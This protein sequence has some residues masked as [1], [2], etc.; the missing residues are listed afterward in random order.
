MILFKNQTKT[1]YLWSRLLN[2]PFWTIYNMLFII[3]YKELHATPLQITLTIAIKPIASLFSS[4]WGSLI[5][6]K[7]NKLITNLVFANILKYAPFLLFPFVT[8]IWFFIASFGFYM[9]FVRGTIPAWMEIIKRNIQGKAREHVFAAGSIVDYIGSAVLPIALGWILDDYTGSWRWIFFGAACIGIVSTGLLWTLPVQEAETS[10]QTSRSVKGALLRPWKE[11]WIL[12]KRRPDFAKFQIAFMI[13]G[14]ALMM[15][16]TI[17]P[18]YFVD[19]LHLSY[20]EI[21]LAIAVCKAVGFVAASPFWVR[22]FHKMNLYRFCSWVTLSA[23][24]FPLILILG[25]FNSLALYVAYF[26]YGIMQAG[27]EL[28]WNLSGPHFAGDEDSTPYSGTNVLSVGLRG[29]VAPFI[30]TLIYDSTNSLM[31]M[32]A[33]FALCLLAT[34]RLYAFSKIKAYNSLHLDKK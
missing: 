14:S 2:T 22:L 3:L 15:L 10:V 7:P 29:C 28:S 31:V 25:Y 34:E 11:A 21:A 9:I 20:M 26:I 27:S 12:L 6:R 33:S 19:V 1:V 16:M 5:Y 23:A 18:M 17:L 4:Y 13:G 24:L 30:G 32:I 8:N